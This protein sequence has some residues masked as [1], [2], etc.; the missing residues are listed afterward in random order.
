MANLEVNSTD[1]LHGLEFIERKNSIQISVIN[2][3]MQYLEQE[4]KKLSSTV[5]A[6]QNDMQYLRQIQQ[7]EK[8]V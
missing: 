6:I 4:N 7:T 2:S 8:G 3:D 5:S 1:L